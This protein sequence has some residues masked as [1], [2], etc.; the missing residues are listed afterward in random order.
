M[1]S[2]GRGVVVCDRSLAWLKIQ[3]NLVIIMCL[4]IFCKYILLEFCPTFLHHATITTT[5]SWVSN[6]H[7]CLTGFTYDIN[8]I[9]SWWYAAQGFPKKNWTQIEA[10]LL[11]NTL[12]ILSTKY[13]RT[14]NEFI[15]LES[16]ESSGL[17]WA[18]IAV[19]DTPHGTV[20]VAVFK[21][22]QVCV[23]RDVCLLCE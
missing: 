4:N 7:V 20:C 15:S 19:Q 16:V 14:W 12:V 2:V 8:H 17:I 13:Y 23:S 10:I 6:Y 11:H 1:G 21:P 22:G 9:C 5:F 18:C 3:N